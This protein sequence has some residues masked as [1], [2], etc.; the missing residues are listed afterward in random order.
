MAAMHCSAD[1]VF[2][3]LAKQSHPENRKLVDIA[4]D[5]A[6]SPERRSPPAGT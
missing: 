6:T 2:G 4:A 5:I 1:D 3:L